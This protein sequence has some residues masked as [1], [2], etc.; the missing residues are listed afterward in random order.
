[1]LHRNPFPRATGKVMSRAAAPA[2]ALT[3]EPVPGLAIRRIPR[4]SLERSFSSDSTATTNRR[5][6]SVA[7]QGKGQAQQR[8]R[9]PTRARTVLLRMPRGRSS[10]TRDVTQRV[11]SRDGTRRVNGVA[12]NCAVACCRAAVALIWIDV[13]AAAFD[14]LPLES[15]GDNGRSCSDAEC[16]PI[17]FEP[18]TSRV[19]REVID[20]E[21][22]DGTW[23]VNGVA[24]PA[25]PSSAAER[26]PHVSAAA[27]DSLPLESKGGPT[28]VR[29]SDAECA[30]IVHEPERLA[31][32]EK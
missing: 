6:V 11:P 18:D 26:P 14:K 3:R 24:V 19:R 16:A 27:F 15:K 28:V 7:F 2:V 10:S 5:A 21:F 25:A 12:A 9:N 13:T 22:R 23:R 32:D 31:R 20:D 4:D 17:I 1:M 30:S 8:A 29:S